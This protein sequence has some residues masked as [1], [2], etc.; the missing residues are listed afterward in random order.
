[1]SVV[2]ED[3]WVCV[4][5]GCSRKWCQCMECSGRDR[6]GVAWEE[7]GSE[8]RIG[9]VLC[10]F[11]LSCANECQRGCV[12][13]CHANSSATPHPCR[14]PT[15]TQSHTRSLPGVTVLLSYLCGSVMLPGVHIDYKNTSVVTPYFHCFLN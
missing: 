3:V 13:I 8:K 1:M 2:K 4:C 6:V 5:L 9:T 11:R 10:K 7:E 15:G 12:G 14:H